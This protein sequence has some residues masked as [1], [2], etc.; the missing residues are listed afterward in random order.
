MR[1]TRTAKLDGFRGRAWRRAV[2]SLLR[3]GSR[4]RSRS[5]YCARHMAAGAMEVPEGLLS[6]ADGMVRFLEP[7]VPNRD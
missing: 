7:F 1:S 5:L 4:S 6:D 2:R 3:T